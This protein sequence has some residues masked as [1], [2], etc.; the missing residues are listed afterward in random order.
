MAFASIDEQVSDVAGRSSANGAGPFLSRRRMLLQTSADNLQDAQAAVGDELI[1]YRTT[2][3]SMMAKAFGVSE[4]MVASFAVRLQL[5]TTEACMS[6]TELQRSLR[7][8]LQDFVTGSISAYHTLQIMRI[9]VDRAGITC[10][11][12]RRAGKVLLSLSEATAEVEMLV[13]F[14]QT[15]SPTINLERIAQNAGVQNI[16]PLR[17]PITV[18]TPSGIDVVRTPPPYGDGGGGSTALIAGVCC[19]VGGLVLAAIGGFLFMR[20]RVR[21]EQEVVTVTGVNVDDLKTQIMDDM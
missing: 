6:K 3:D 19:A 10:T 20:S 21:A 17:V 1:E 9:S 7:A 18:S 15:D 8:T 2:P 13:V 16:E 14:K 4:E 12:G 5:S 11:D